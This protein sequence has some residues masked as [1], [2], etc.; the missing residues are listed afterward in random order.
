[1]RIAFDLDGTLIPARGGTE[2]VRF[3]PLRLVFR[4]RLRPGAR[5]L[6]RDL[7]AD[8]HDV[9]IYTTSLRSPLYLHAWFRLLG[10]CL[11]GVVNKLRH[12]AALVGAPVE[13]RGLSKFP[14]AFG[15]DLLVD[16]LPGVAVEGQRHGFRVAVVPAEGSEWVSVVRRAVAP[17]SGG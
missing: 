14:P 16:D 17:A 11:G 1:M 5:Q 7:A 2:S 9:W 13:V 4:E 10:V 6:L 3:A 15:I 8:G 12:D